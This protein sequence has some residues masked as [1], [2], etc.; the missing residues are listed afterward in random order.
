RAQRV[1]AN[2]GVTAESY[3]GTALQSVLDQFPRD[4]FFQM[5]SD[6][7]T[8]WASGILDLNLRPRTRVFSR[9]DEFDRFVS[10]MEKP[11]RA[12]AFLAT[13]WRVLQNLRSTMQR[14]DDLLSVEYHSVTPYRLGPHVVKYSLVPTGATHEP[15]GGDDPDHLRAA[16]KESLGRGDA[17]FDFRIH[18]RT[19]PDAM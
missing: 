6:E 5:S 4:E 3:N 12:V 17:T 18:V 10:V 7:L 11:V 15:A 1:A 8:T 16:L 19:Q 13:H 9:A 2:L 14:H